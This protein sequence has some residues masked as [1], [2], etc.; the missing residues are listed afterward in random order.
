M[1]P[2]FRETDTNAHIPVPCGHTR[3]VHF[4]LVEV[5][6]RLRALTV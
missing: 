2:V 6:H 3:A 1:S 4:G 5:A